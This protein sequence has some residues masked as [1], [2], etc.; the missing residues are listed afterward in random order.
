MCILKRS[1]SGAFSAL[2]PKGDCTLTPKWVPSF[3]PRGATHHTGAR[4]LC[5]R[6]KKL[7]P[8]NLASKSG[9]YES[10]KFFYMPQSWDMGQ[11]LSLPLRRKSMLRIIRT[12]EKSSAF[13]RR[14]PEVSMLTTRPPKQLTVGFVWYFFLPWSHQ[15]HS[16]SSFSSSS[17][18]RIN[19]RKKLNTRLQ[20]TSST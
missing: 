17:R 16:A 7:L 15:P 18:F 3:I 9:I 13:C 8:R 5:Q 2:H 4:D 19:K 11:I 1:L 10:T 20:K 12:P 6:R 14:V